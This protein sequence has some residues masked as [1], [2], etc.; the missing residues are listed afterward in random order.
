MVGAALLVA[1]L[2]AVAGE[3]E[4]DDSDDPQTADEIRADLRRD[5][6]DK[7]VEGIERSLELRCLPDAILE[8][9]DDDSG[10]ITE[11]QAERIEACAERIQARAI[12]GAQ[13]TNRI[14][15]VTA[16][17][18]RVIRQTVR[19][20]VSDYEPTEEDPDDLPEE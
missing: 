16:L 12:A 20:F 5:I 15:G 2:G 1:P 13:S 17:T 4:D 7:L 10:Q 9:G 18:P 11:Q 3:D 19:N 6:R 8:F 14:C